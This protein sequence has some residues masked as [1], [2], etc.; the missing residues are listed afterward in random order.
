MY[1]GYG[2]RSVGKYK[3]RYLWRIAIILSAVVLVIGAVPMVA[4]MVLFR[5]NF[6]ARAENI[7]ARAEFLRIPFSVRY[8]D[9]TGYPRRQTHFYSGGNRLAAFI[10]GEENDKGL[11]VISHGF[12]LGAE[13]YFNETMYFVDNGW[14]VFAFDNT[15]SHNSE[16][17]SVR[18][19]PQS[20]LDLDAALTYIATQGWGLPVMLYGH[21]WGGFAACV[22]L[23]KGHDIASVVSL[24]GFATA[25]GVMHEVAR[26]GIGL[27]LGAYIAYPYLWLHQRL[28]FGRYAGLSAV[29]GINSGTA[30]VKIIHGTQDRLIGYGG[31][32]IIAQRGRVTNPNAIFVSRSEPHHNGHLNLLRCAEAA[33]FIE[34]E[35]N[36]AFQELYDR[37]SGDIPC[38]I[39]AAFHAEYDRRRRA[40]ALDMDFMDAINSFFKSHLR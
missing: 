38:E 16:G 33:A 2:R 19:L 22:V 17:R 32:S 31:S 11:I 10:Y 39:L 13:Y 25:M 6:G 7:E 21:S 14:R 27:G 40:S 12:T 30:P 8:E 3:R 28:M 34:H 5:R 1:M 20:V 35:F 26:D 29:D 4:T 23:A 36:P 24:A 18:G 37:H 15:G 9:V